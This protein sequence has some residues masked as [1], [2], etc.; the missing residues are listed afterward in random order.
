M[1]YLAHNQTAAHVAQLNKLRFAEKLGK[2]VLLSDKCLA[3]ES[4]H[5]SKIVG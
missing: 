5:G 1:N 2:T 3:N 4:I